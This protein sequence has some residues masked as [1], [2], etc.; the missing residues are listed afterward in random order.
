MGLRE[1]SSSCVRQ[2]DESPRRVM[3]R[4]RPRFCILWNLADEIDGW[5][6]IG[7]KTNVY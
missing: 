4:L 5:E 3:L 6:R 1:E 2:G 7:R